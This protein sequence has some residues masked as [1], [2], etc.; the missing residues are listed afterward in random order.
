M[1]TTTSGQMIGARRQMELWGGAH[2]FH[3]H[4]HRARNGHV[5]RISAG[6]EGEVYQL[7]IVPEGEDVSRTIAAAMTTLT[8]E[9]VTK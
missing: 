6:I 5:V 1:I 8:M 9:S 3:I 7:W 2:N 4:I